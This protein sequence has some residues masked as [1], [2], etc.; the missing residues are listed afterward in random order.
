MD[1]APLQLAPVWDSGWGKHTA[2][3]RDGSDHPDEMFPT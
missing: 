3:A 2:S 1:G